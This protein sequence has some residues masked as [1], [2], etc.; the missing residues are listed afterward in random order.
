M[1]HV[2]EI[3]SDCRV[4]EEVNGFQI[5]RCPGITIQNLTLDGHGRGDVRG[6][7][8]YSGIINTGLYRERRRPT[9]V[10]MTVRG[11][12]FRGLMGRGIAFYGVAGARIEGNSFHRIRAQAIEIDHFSSGHVLNN[13]VDGAEVGVTINDA[14]E[15]LVEGNVLRNCRYGIRFMD[16]ISAD[17]VN[18]GN[19]VRDNQ[20]G[21]GCKLG[22]EFR[23]P[24]QGNVVRGNRF[25]GLA[26]KDR[27][28]NAEGNTVD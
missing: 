26:K 8:I 22:V 2:K 24:M 28:V 18:T 23:D 13:H 14:F 4:L 25:L 12:T 27:V 10:G 5:K 9:T 7:T 20:I 21:P 16:V 6:H 17:W 11:C 15:S 19:V 1:P 3:P